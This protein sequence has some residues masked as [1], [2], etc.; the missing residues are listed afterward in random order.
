[1]STH[2]IETELHGLLSELVPGKTW[3]KQSGVV[4]MSDFA[5]HNLDSTSEDAKV[6]RPLALAR[7]MYENERSSK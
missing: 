7:V 2:A 5:V 4:E 3:Y 1:M 6:Q